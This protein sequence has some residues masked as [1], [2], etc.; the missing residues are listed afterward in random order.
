MPLLDTRVNDKNLTQTFV[1][2]LVLQILS[3]VAQTEREAI[4][5]RQ[6][7]GID[8]ALER[9]VK[10]GRTEKAVPPEFE[11]I[12]KKCLAGEIS[13]HSAARTLNMPYSTFAKKYKKQ[14]TSINT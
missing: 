13:V 8:A 10:F 1:A 2:D 12:A 14:C 6:R 9:G 7:E 4:K 5:Q 3:Y 11:A